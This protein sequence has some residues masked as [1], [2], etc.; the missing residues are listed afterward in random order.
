M[1]RCDSLI[2]LRLANSSEDCRA[3]CFE[4]VDWKAADRFSYAVILWELLTRR[5]PYEGYRGAAAVR[6]VGPGI[7]TLWASEGQR[8]AWPHHAPQGWRQLAE[9]CWGEDP[10]ARPCVLRT[11]FCAVERQCFKR[12]AMFGREFRAIAKRLRAIHPDIASWSNPDEPPPEP[13]PEPE[14]EAAAEPEPEPE[15]AQPRAL[16]KPQKRE[17][18]SADAP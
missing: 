13:E 18:A 8:P 6:A 3:C 1:L 2:V 12:V 17:G 11:A 7:V 5:R 4:G 15:P 9:D 16:P 14:P 10:A